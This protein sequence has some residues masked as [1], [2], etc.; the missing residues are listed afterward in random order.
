MSDGAG[1]DGGRTVIGV[2][3]GGTG[4]KG[5]PVDTST[6]SL[7]RERIR[8]LTPHPATPAAV[9]GV[10]AELVGQLDCP[11]PLGVTL[12]A[13]VQHG[14]ARTAAN[15]DDAWV[16]SDAAALLSDATGRPVA[17][18]NDADAAGVAEMRFGAGVGQDGVVVM[19]T[20]GTGIGSAVFADGRLV[21]NTELGH[22]PLHGG[23]AEDWAAA[24]VREEEDLGWKK[25]AHR[26]EAYLQLLEKLLWPDLIIVGGGVSKHADRFLPH[27]ETRTTV[28]PAQMHNDAGIAGA[29][30]FAPAD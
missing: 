13:V 3:I 19:V 29:A 1:T 5:A 9:A 23:D 26:V 7:V 12:P 8:L 4:I 17:V 6:G 24:S 21:P 2:D 22:L 20:F 15:I 25:W 10:V 28:V 18:V 30:L 11:G 16:D 27:I 14:V